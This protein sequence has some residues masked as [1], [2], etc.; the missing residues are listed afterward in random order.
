M[1]EIKINTKIYPLAVVMQAAYELLDKE[2]PQIKGDPEVEI[3]VSYKRDEMESLFQKELV[4]V[5]VFESKADK[6]NELK[7]D[8]VKK[9]LIGDVEYDSNDSEEDPEDI[10]IPWEEKYGE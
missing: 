10:M 9:A 6:E 4:K 1:T 8:L 2:T 7:T 3:I 5:S